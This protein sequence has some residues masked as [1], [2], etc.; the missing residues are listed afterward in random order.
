MF[1]QRFPFK[2]MHKSGNQNRVADALSRRVDVLAVISAEAIRFE[3]MK[4]LYA[5]DCDF[6]E[7]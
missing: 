4:E 5:E 7:I 6:Y 1:L 2:L 3:Q